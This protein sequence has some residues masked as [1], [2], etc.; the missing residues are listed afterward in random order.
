MSAT[1]VA[2][3]AGRHEAAHTA[4]PFTGV[5]SLVRLALRR[6][7]LRLSV[8]IAAL[9]LMMVYAPNAIKLAYP[10]EAARAA[11]VNLMKTP[12]GMIL[13]GPMF[14]RNE[15]D[16][17]VMMANELMLTLII[18]ASI[19]SIL[20]V[21]R[22]TRAEEESGA[23]ELVLSSV[24]GRYARTGAALIL[25]GGVNAILAVTMTLAM[26]S[27]GFGV[28]DTAAMCLGVTGVSMVFGAVAAVTAQL[29]RQARAATGAAMGVLA[30]AALV[31]GAGD[32]INNSG[33]ALSWFSPIA[34]AQQMRSFVD[35][36]W[37]PFALL[38]VLAVVLMALAAMLESRRQYDDGVIPSTGEHPNAR[39]ITSVFGLHLTL[40]RGQTIGW[41]VGLFLSGLT[42][43]S[44]TKSL[45]DAAKENELLQR[46]LTAQ[47]TDGVYTTMTQFLAAA[48]TA[49]VVTAVVRVFNDEQSG[50][51]EAVLAGAVS[52]WRWLLTAVAAAIV[53]SAVLMFFAGLGNG[54]GAGLTTGEPEAIWRLTLAGLAYVP[55]MATIAGLAALAVALRHPWI[56]WLAV[57]FVIISLYLGA[58]LRLP[59]WL[60]D[61]SPVGQTKA[62]SEYSAVALT[63]MV[64]VAAALTLA[65]GTIYRRRDAL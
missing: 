36:R 25:V 8:W 49:Y 18:A 26:A 51:G 7:R 62:P 11:R 28:V 12:A 4:S 34:W 58:L 50:L 42:F 21:I 27:T 64:V 48:A 37:W 39:P 29:W 16:L 14:G 40:Q 17:G 54:L 61:A 65:A 41:A 19:L 33:S 57:T 56:G 30:L 59:Q 44:M 6:D 32:V 1:V 10:D 38:V 24:V 5:A 22:H 47:G 15:T 9:T 43:G 46:V 52:R 35:L 63:V 31:R 60:L 2:P 3:H 20:T 55:A 23:A 45:L 53:G 13:A